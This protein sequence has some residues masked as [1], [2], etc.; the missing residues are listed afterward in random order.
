MGRRKQYQTPM[1]CNVILDQAEVKEVEQRAR[2]EGLS[3]SMLVRRLVVSVLSR[4]PN[5]P[6]K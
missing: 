1:R 5:E 3:F 2:K 6:T 4:P